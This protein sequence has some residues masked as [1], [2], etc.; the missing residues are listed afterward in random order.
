MTFAQEDK[1]ALLYQ[2]KGSRRLQILG[3]LAFATAFFVLAVFFTIAILEGQGKFAVLGQLG[4]YLTL[5]MPCMFI[6]IA[7]ILVALS[8]KSMPFRVYQRGVTMTRV[9]FRDGLAGRETFVP[10]GEIARVTYEGTYVPR[11]GYVEYFRFHLVDGGNFNVSVDDG[12][13]ERV[14][15][16]LMEVLRCEVEGPG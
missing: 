3:G 4:R 1:G 6:L 13:E 10:A 9:P 11:G 5:V 14:T 16:L 12:D 8:F 7:V 2:R 15:G